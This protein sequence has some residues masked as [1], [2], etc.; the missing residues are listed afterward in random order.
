MSNFP[1]KASFHTN[2]EADCIALLSACW[3]HRGERQTQKIIGEWAGLTQQRVSKII[4][5]EREW[6]PNDSILAIT[7]HKYGYLYKVFNRA[8][9]VIDV[10]YVGRITDK[11]D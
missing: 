8:G 4:N 7:A 11:Y 2:S 10:V 3:K 1:R 5:S 6:G 9:L